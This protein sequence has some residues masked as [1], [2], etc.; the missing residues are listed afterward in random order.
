M[1]NM[2]LN[3]N[4]NQALDSDSWDENFCAVSLHGSMEHLA[5][6]ALNI[7]ESLSR[8][9]KYILGKSIKSDKANNV[10]DLKGMGKAM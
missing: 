1:F 2:Q 5:S 3:Y 8:M 4:Y 7:K 10:K 6:D 9:W